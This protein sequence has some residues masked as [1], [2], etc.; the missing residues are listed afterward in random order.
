MRT[1]PYQLH[2]DVFLCLCDNRLV[3]LDLRNNQYLC[4]N[5]RNTQT[6]NTIFTDFRKHTAR[7]P[8]GASGTDTDNTQVVLQALSDRGLLAESDTN[9]KKAVAVTIQAPHNSFLSNVRYP[10][11]TAHLSYWVAFFH[12]SIKASW[13][14]RWYSM[15]RVVQSVESRKQHFAESQIVNKN[16]LYKMTAV[17]HSLRPY[18]ARKYLC[19]YDSLALIEFLAHY[20]L[21]P[22]WVYGIKA[23]PFG[24]HCWVQDDDC[25]LNDSVEHASRF[26]PIMAV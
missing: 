12:A 5:R 1:P 6:A 22:Q 23:E 13:K 21:F 26:T 2:K 19:L 16:S 7:Q 15:Q 17:F 25:V 24:A 11:P 4:L 8:S 10:P 9:G 3:F 18:Y 20:R 14:L